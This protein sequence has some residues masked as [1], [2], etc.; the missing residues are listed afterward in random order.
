MG[1]RENSISISELTPDDDDG[2]GDRAGEAASE[3]LPDMVIM[4]L[5]TGGVP[6]L[7][8][9][10]IDWLG[11]LLAHNTQRLGSAFSNIH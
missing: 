9:W 2:E 10:A 7:C 6:A 1:S 8:K 5:Q 4:N 3:A 11:W